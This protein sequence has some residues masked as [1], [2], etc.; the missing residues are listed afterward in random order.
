MPNWTKEFIAGQREIVSAIWSGPN[1]LDTLC[2]LSISALT[3]IERAHTEIERLEVELSKRKKRKW[4]PASERPDQCPLRTTA[5][6]A[7]AAAPRGQKE[8]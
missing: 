8:G 1:P 6:Y 7:E 2:A 4:H 3:E 5:Q